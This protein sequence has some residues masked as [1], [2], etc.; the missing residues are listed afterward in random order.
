[1][2]SGKRHVGRIASAAWRKS[3]LSISSGHCVEVADR[4]DAIGVRDSTDTEGPVL[5]FTPDEWAAFLGDINM[6]VAMTSSLASGEPGPPG[7]T[8]SPSGWRDL[9][10]LWDDVVAGHSEAALDVTHLYQ[11]RAVGDW[12]EP[13]VA[14]RELAAPRQGPSAPRSEGE[15]MPA[16]DGCVSSPGNPACCFCGVWA[17][18]AG[19]VAV[20]MSGPI[21]RAQIRSCGPIRCAAVSLHHSTGGDLRHGRQFHDRGPL[22]PGDDA[23]VLRLEDKQAGRAQGPGRRQPSRPRRHAHVHRRP[24]CRRA[25]GAG[26]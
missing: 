12:A 6:S 5:E 14:A 23:A 11:A 21:R 3:S 1:M 7:V 4:R 8:T 15:R 26:C 20:A 2:L 9:D 17:R 16:A 24:G 19:G 25:Q 22:L 13:R 10:R 18:R